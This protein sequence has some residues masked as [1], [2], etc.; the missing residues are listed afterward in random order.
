MSVVVLVMITNTHVVEQGK[1]PLCAVS[2]CCPAVD[3]TQ[4][5]AVILTDDHGGKVTLTPAEWEF[6]KAKFCHAPA[7]G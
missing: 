2:N 4:P 6:L 1:I 5:N 3:F 7:Q